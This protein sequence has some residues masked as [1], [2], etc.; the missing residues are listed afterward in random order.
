MKYIIGVALGSFIFCYADIW[1]TVL[2]RT[3]SHADA[4]KLHFAL[5]SLQQPDPFR[6]WNPVP[7]EVEEC[8]EWIAARSS[9]EVRS[10][11]E[12]MIHRLRAVA[13][14]MWYVSH[15]ALWAFRLFHFAQ[16]QWRVREVAW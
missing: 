5:Q 12:A 2:A 9:A 11:R 3:L 14:H 8:L 13:E 7:R 10:E 16:E 1:H 15:G 4:S 6:T